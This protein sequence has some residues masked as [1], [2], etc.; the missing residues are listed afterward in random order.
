MFRHGESRVKTYRSILV[1]AAFVAFATT[2]GLAQH[3]GG[4]SGKSAGHHDGSGT[5]GTETA[6]GPT[7]KAGARGIDLVRHDDG[8]ASPRRRATRSSLVGNGAKKGPSSNVAR[9]AISPPV[10]PAVLPRN[11]IGAVTTNAG[12]HHLDVAHPSAAIAVTGVAAKTSI[13]GNAAAAHH[14]TPHVVPIANASI[15]S[16]G[17]SGT[18]MGHAATS[19]AVLG[20]AAHSVSGIG[21]ASMRTKH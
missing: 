9:P 5:G 18:Q 8:Y 12:A 6:A 4:K 19:P 13:G 2:A 1:A 17:L 21:G 16:T 14:E 20:G 10:V 7:G 15:H 3:G 11:A